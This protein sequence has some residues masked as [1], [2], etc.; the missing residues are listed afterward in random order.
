M[1][2]SRRRR[3]KRDD[4]DFGDFLAGVQGAM[5]SLAATAT[6][7]AQDAGESPTPRPT[8]PPPAARGPVSRTHP[9]RMRLDDL[10]TR[11][12]YSGAGYVF[13]SDPHV[14][15]E[16]DEVLK[17]LASIREEDRRHAFVLGA[18]VQSLGG[19]PSPGRSP[20]PIR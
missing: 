16:D 17:T 15:P 19:V 12:F 1:P 2:P 18:L 14:V 7:A 20:S 9:L 5:G 10:L 13:E 11:C 3:W 8:T 4:D 6:T